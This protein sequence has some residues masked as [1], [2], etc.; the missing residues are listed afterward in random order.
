MSP[1]EMILNLVCLDRGIIQLSDVDSAQKQFAALPPPER[2][3]VSR[4]IRKLAKKF[5]N[6]SS[7]HPG[8]SRQ[9][10]LSAGLDLESPRSHKHRERYEK[11]KVL[12]A[13]RFLM[14]VIHGES[15]RRPREC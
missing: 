7:S 9:K 3:A 12:Y 8:V 10:Y 13:R 2:R 14:S 11:I 1:E 6:N 4:K 5:I 15:R